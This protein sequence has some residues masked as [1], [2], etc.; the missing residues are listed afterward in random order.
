MSPKS[1][2]LHAFQTLPFA[3]IHPPHCFVVVPRVA[4]RA[5]AIDPTVG[6]DLPNATMCPPATVG[7]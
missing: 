4:I 2:S 7:R 6:L 3:L 5:L 1:L